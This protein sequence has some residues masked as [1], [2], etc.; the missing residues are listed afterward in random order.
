MWRGALDAGCRSASPDGAAYTACTRMKWI[1][2][3]RRPRRGIYIFDIVSTT[4]SGTIKFGSRR[5]AGFPHRTAPVSQRIDQFAGEL[6]TAGFPH[7]TQ[8]ELQR[9]DQDKLQL[10]GEIIAVEGYEWAL[11]GTFI[12]LLPGAFIVCTVSTVRQW[13]RGKARVSEMRETGR[14]TTE[15]LSTSLLGAAKLSHSLANP[16]PEPEDD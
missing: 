13:L 5:T 3:S 10:K 8:P 1:I 4:Q 9:I 7:N 16:E 12:I 2:W 11:V 15:S 14:F 6:R